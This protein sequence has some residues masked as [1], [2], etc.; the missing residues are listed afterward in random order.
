MAANRVK[1]G[2]GIA[3]AA[4]PALGSNGDLTGD[5]LADLWAVAAD[6]KAVAFRGTAAGIDA[7][8]VTGG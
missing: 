4:Y 8:P 2:S 5:G 6:G 3:R 1:I 7:S